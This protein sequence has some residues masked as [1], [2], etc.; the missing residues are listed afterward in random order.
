MLV[1]TATPR[2]SGSPRALF[3]G[4]ALVA[5]AAVGGWWL[6]G[7]S[8]APEPIAAPSSVLVL[9][10]VEVEV[11]PA[12][13]SSKAA[14]GPDV[15]GARAYAPAA[16]LPARA[17]VVAGSVR[18]PSLVPAALRPELPARL[19]APRRTRLAGLAA[20]TYGPV[21]G[22]D[23]VLQVTV[24]PTTGGAVAVACSA[25][26]QSWSV[27]LGCASGV[28]RLVPMRGHPLAPAHDLAFRQRAPGALREL[29]ADRVP[30]REALARTRRAAAAAELARAHRTAAAALAPLAVEGPSAATVAAL[31]RAAWGYDSLAAA[32]RRDERRR[33]ARA[34][35]KIRRADAA[36]ASALER[37]RS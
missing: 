19:P 32:T 4:V 11:D 35:A 5:I 27:A 34:R 24:V 18:D 14:P 37:L 12:W 8:R 23:R 10:H 17:L 26:P 2:R 16:G 13:T 33:F 15:E 7:V 22:E 1:D 6:G 20:W 28:R 3:A 25:P 29:D 9:G 36:L 31:R 21:R 30:L